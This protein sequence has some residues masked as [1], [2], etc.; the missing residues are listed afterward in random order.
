MFLL[1]A[2][3]SKE[4][5]L[6]LADELT[7]AIGAMLST[8]FRDG[9]RDFSGEEL[10]STYNRIWGE[11]VAFETSKGRPP[12]VVNVEILF[13]ALEFLC[14]PMEYTPSA[15]VA[16]WKDSFRAHVSQH[17]DLHFEIGQS[18]QTSLDGDAN[19]LGRAVGDAVDLWI[20]RKE[21]RQ[22]FSELR[23]AMLEGLAKVLSVEGRSFAYL[24]PIA[25]WPGP[26]SVV[27]LNYDWGVESAAESAS[28][29]WTTGAESWEGSFNWR[30]P[31]EP[32]LRILKL[33]GSTG[34][35]LTRAT[36]P[37]RIGLDRISVT[38]PL[39]NPSITVRNEPALIFGAGNKMR[40]FGP[41]TAMLVE[42]ERQLVEASRLVVVGYSFGD[43]HVNEVLR[44]TCTRERGLA[45]TIIDPGLPDWRAG[46]HADFQSQ[47]R[48]Q[49][50]TIGNLGPGR[51]GWTLREGCQ[52]LSVGAGEGLAAL[53]P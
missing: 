48:A 39:K 1:G 38:S 43:A 37:S 49:L 27:T 8:L 30:W 22:V 46:H 24:E 31:D 34:W 18:I 5:G 4:A 44:R 53:L 50:R 2:G 33:H 26:R 19:A 16:G 40:S 41:Y 32:Q 17:D 6:F 51:S 42:F 3:A 7:E 15:F 21:G 29:E 47:F 13:A 36:D 25:T 11:M 20:G 45:V 9:I 52:E 35:H 14:A 10:R 28:I 23:T 12:G